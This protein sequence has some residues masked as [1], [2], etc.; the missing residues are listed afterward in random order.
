MTPQHHNMYQVSPSS[1]GMLP[2]FWENLWYSLI[3]KCIGVV[4]IRLFVNQL[5]DKK[6]SKA[7]KKYQTTQK[8]LLKHPYFE[9]KYVK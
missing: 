4:H 2:M 5:P 6:L 9:A 3:E 8:L 1:T 7:E